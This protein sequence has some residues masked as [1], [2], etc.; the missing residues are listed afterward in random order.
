MNSDMRTILVT[1][2]AGFIG[3]CFVRQWI[4]EDEAGVVNLDKLTYAGN[5]DSLADGRATIRAT[6]SSRAT[7]ATG[8]VVG[9][10]WPST[11][12][13]DGELRGRVARRP[14]DRRAGRVRRD[15]RASARF[16]CWRPPGRYWDRLRPSRGERS[17]ASCTS[18]PTRSTARWGPTGR[19]T[20]TT[21]Y[22][23]SSPYSASKAAGRPL[24]AGVSPHLRAAGARDQLLE[25]L[26][27]VP[28]S[29]EADPAD[30]PQRR[31]RASRCPST[32]TGRTSATGCTSRTTAGRF[33]RV[34]AAAGPAKSTTSAATASGRTSTWSN[35]L[36]TGRRAAARL[37]PRPLLRR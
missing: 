23:P 20:E 35:D 3:S 21:P 7:S 32:A 2:G 29:R 25:Q 19:F 15:Q 11:A 12:G 10:C 30:D 34:L 24:R 37:A 16:G 31:W 28:V 4:A 18:R 13:G 5:L 22:D 26:R 17:S 6:C 8:P 14:L 9:R 33:W 27:A 36:P 1:G